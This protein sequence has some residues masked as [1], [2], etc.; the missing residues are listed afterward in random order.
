[1]KVLW[2]CNIIPPMV[3]KA[4]GL[5]YSIKEGWITGI[6][7]EM[8]EQEEALELGIAYPVMER[9][10]K[11]SFSL[12]ITSSIGKKVKK[13]TCYEFEEDT[14]RPQI[15]GG[16]PL[17]ERMEEIFQDFQPE[18]LHLFGTEYGHSL[19]AART[20]PRKEKIL[21]GLQGIVAECAKYYMA[22]LPENVQKRKTFRDLLKKD[23]M[24][25]QQEKFYIRA[26]RERETLEKAG[27]VTGRTKFDF[28]AAKKINPSLTYFF[29]NETMRKEFYRGE[30]KL[31]NCKP[32][33][34]FFSQAD[35]PLKGF[36]HML[37]AAYLLEKKYP[38]IS[39]RVAGNS[40]TGYTTLKEK[41]KIS[42][43]GNY[44]RKMIGRGKLKNK[45]T[46]LGRL[47]AEEMKA[48]YLNSHCYVCASSIENSP[49]SLAEA[50]LLGTP[51]VAAKTGG[52]PS[53]LEEGKE[54]LL[55]ERG[56]PKELAACIEKIWEDDCLAQKLS[57]QEK[58]RAHKTHDPK[59]NYHRLIEI[60]REMLS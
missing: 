4:L 52:I 5:D 6:L 59:I 22:E 41:I 31:E 23:S 21:V 28:E 29:M 36:H 56:N 9:K 12:F 51:V 33:Q 39:I 14:A 16:K 3:A 27:C 30:W 17:E 35:Y 58:L 26:E 24:K 19:A 47:S 40:I 60:Y 53:L 55:F 1:M 49:N 44:I 34:I 50:M 46:F 2:V 13:I 15:Y 7:E 8:I 10:E 20:F 38:G 32:Y 43:Y 18:L 42:A 54:G 57:W 45:I 25:Q 11:G 48:E 37:Q